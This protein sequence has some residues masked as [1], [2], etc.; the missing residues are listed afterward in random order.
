MRRVGD[1]YF[2]G[3]ADEERRE[4]YKHCEAAVA[5]DLLEYREQRV[6]QHPAATREDHLRRIA[7]ALPMEGAALLEEEGWVLRRTAVLVGWEAEWVLVINGDGSRPDA[8]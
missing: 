8:R 4:R 3:E 7:V 6:V 1:R 5:H 2:D